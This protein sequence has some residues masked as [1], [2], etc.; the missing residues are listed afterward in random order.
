MGWGDKDL[1]DALHLLPVQRA[2][3][4]PTDHPGCSGRAPHLIRTKR[5]W[6]FLTGRDC[7]RKASWPPQTD[8][9][10]SELSVNTES[11][12]RIMMCTVLCGTLQCTCY[13]L[14]HK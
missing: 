7:P 4:G 10:K 1:K 13:G 8:W 12:L 5:R 6:V 14:F 3:E 11:P 2:P 9:G